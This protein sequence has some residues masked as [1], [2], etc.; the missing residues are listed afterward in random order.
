LAADPA[1]VVTYR[2]EELFEVFSR[3]KKARRLMR[4]RGVIR[5]KETN[6]QENDLVQKDTYR[7]QLEVINDIQLSFE[8][9][10]SR[11][12]ALKDH[13][14][15]ADTLVTNIRSMDAYLNALVDEYENML[16]QFDAASFELPLNGLPNLY[17]LIRP[18]YDETQLRT[19]CVEPYKEVLQLIQ[20]DIMLVET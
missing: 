20:R 16:P 8:S 6:G 18:E 2:A 5:K 3:T 11:I 4:A 17:D 14:S 12:K 10:G 13:F 1:F 7:E 19:Q 15:R 9:L